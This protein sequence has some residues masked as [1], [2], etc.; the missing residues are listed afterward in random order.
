MGGEGAGGD[1]VG[2]HWTNG[3]DGREGELNHDGVI[4]LNGREQISFS[5]MFRLRWMRDNMMQR[6]RAGP[7]SWVH[8]LLSGYRIPLNLSRFCHINS[9]GLQC[10]KQRREL[11]HAR[12]Q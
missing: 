10:Q 11:R 2:R 5:E 1:D 9:P 12:S 4:V 7:V 6:R 3:I 8:A